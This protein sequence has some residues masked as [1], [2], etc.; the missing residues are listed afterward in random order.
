[1]TLR[2][3]SIPFAAAL[4][5]AGYAGVY[6]QSVPPTA[7]IISDI[8]V[9]ATALTDV[10]CD[11][12]GGTQCYETPWVY[13]SHPHSLTHALTRSLTHSLADSLARSLA[14][15]LHRRRVQRAGAYAAPSRPGAHGVTAI[16]TS[17]ARASRPVD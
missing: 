6:T 9:E 3:A 15:V 13:G 11:D 14:Q 8:A 1:M 17:P 16:G 2:L 12:V 7:P 4:L 10:G 5:A